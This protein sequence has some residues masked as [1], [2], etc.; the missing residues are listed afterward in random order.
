MHFSYRCARFER[1]CTFFAFTSVFLTNA[2]GCWSLL[3]VRL[4]VFLCHVVHTEQSVW[5]YYFCCPSTAG[6]IPCRY[7][8]IRFL[9]V[10]LRPLPVVLKLQLQIRS[11]GSSC[12]SVLRC[13][14]F[15]P[16]VLSKLDFWCSTREICIEC[17]NI[18]IFGQ[19]VG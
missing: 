16:A 19:Q 1:I 12:F 9:V 2:T 10:V 13:R 6:N 5:W 15:I 11:H 14:R 3:W 7:C 17:F 8:F 4:H 18:F